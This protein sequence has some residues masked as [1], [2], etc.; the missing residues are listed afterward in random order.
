MIADRAAPLVVLHAFVGCVPLIRRILP[1]LQSALDIPALPIQ[2]VA[3]AA[4]SPNVEE[5]SHIALEGS[6]ILGTVYQRS[7]HNQM[8]RIH[9]S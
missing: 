1:K 4:H 7:S 5:L 3:I 2:H 8:L 6:Y 9:G